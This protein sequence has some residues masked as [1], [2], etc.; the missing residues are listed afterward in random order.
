MGQTIVMMSGLNKLSF[1]IATLLMACIATTAAVQ[2][3]KRHPIHIFIFIDLRE[4]NLDKPSTVAKNTLSERL[5]AAGFHVTTNRREAELIVDGTISSHPALVTDE[6]KREGGVNADAT[7][8][9][10][11]LVGA[12]VVATSVERSAPGDW[13]VQA[14]RVG[15]DRLIEVAGR[16]ADDMFSGDVV[17]QVAGVEVGPAPKTEPR[18][19][20]TARKPA[21]QNR[22]MS[23]MEVVWLVQNFAPE[24]RIVAALRKYGIK[25]KPHDTAVNQLRNF[26]A[27]EAV[28]SA[29]KTSNVV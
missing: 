11:L 24:E 9:V 18:Q 29:V 16:V 21:G 19:V 2:Q 15:E 6:V 1:T 26:G 13:G 8:S 10:R 14:E 25:F 17:Q 23:F 7:A 28:I 27:S 4:T 12:E 22:A 5:A 3:T 20:K